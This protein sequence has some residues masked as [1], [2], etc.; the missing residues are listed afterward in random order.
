MRHRS[1][2]GHALPQRELG[3]RD[4]REDAVEDVVGA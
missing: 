2:A 1:D 3:D 4:G